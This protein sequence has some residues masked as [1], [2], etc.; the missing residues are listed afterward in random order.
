MAAKDFA[1]SLITNDQHEKLL[2]TKNLDFSFQFQDSR[3]RGNISFQN[4]YYMTVLRLLSQNIPSVKDLHLPLIYQ[5]ITKTG[6]GLILVTGPTGSGK[7]TTLAA[8]I[9]EINSNYAKHIITIEDPIE[10]VHVHKKSIMEQKEIGRDVPD[11][12]T[13]LIGAMRQNPQVILFGEMRDMHEIEMALKLAETG[14]LVFSTLH[15]RSAYQTISRIID[16]FPAGQQNQI[17]LQLA[18]TLVAV[19]SQRLLKKSDGSGM[20]LAK[21]ILVKNTAISHLIRENEL[22]QIP[23][24]MQT[25]SR[26]GMQIIE[27]DLLQFI[28]EGDITLEEGL[29]YANMPKFIKE[30]VNS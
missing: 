6:Q 18:D 3:F 4:G 11:Y 8:M 2:E 15:T 1:Q 17:R 5:D 27:H 25:S 22:H 9:D 30:N 28:N 16:A 14:H 7:S 29:K 10:Y 12:N 20:I 21:E 19:F 23:S 26:E 24:V 13:A